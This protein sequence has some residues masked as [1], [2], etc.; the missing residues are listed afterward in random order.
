MKNLFRVLAALTFVSLA[1]GFDYIRDGPPS[2]QDVPLPIK[3]D[4][5]TIPIQIKLGTTQTLSDGSN[6]STSI[7]A[8]MQSWNAV[9]GS[10]QFQPQIVAEGQAGDRN[11]ISEVVFSST[12]FGTAFDTNVLAVTT[13]IPSR[14]NGNRRVEADV[15]FNTARTWDSYRGPRF[16]RT[17]IDIQRTAIHELGHALGLDH[18][19]E[20]TPPQSVSA[21]MNSR[22]SDVDAL[23]TDDITGGP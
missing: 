7:Q 4:L 16:G 17:A 14:T 9:I 13:T 15:I 8:A 23:T 19:D 5:R 10:S 2:A 6:F 21:I 3:W 20:A 11:G 18:P 22:I 1:S 12:V